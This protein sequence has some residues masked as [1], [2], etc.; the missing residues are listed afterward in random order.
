MPPPFTGHWIE[1]SRLVYSLFFTIRF[2]TVLSLGLQMDLDNTQKTFVA[3]IRRY[4]KPHHLFWTRLNWLRWGLGPYLLLLTTVQE[5]EKTPWL[6]FTHAFKSCT[7]YMETTCLSTWFMKISLS[8]ISSLCF[9]VCKVR[10]SIVI[11][12]FNMT[13]FLSYQLKEL[14]HGILSNYDLVQNYL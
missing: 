2:F 9:F 12:N 13:H 6:S 14:T 3:A 10:S 11:I 1:I 8:M 5:M 7:N 4:R